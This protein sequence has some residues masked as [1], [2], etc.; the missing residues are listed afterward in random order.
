[1]KF[2]VAS[3]DIGICLQRARAVTEFAKLQQILNDGRRAVGIPPLGEAVP[4]EDAGLVVFAEA[5]KDI[6]AQFLEFARMLASD[7]LYH[8]TAG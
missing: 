7:D 1:M 5:G 4:T 3:S 8:S 2:R 6:E